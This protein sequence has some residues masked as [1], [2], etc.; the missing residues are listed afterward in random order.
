MTARLDA[1]PNHGQDRSPLPSEM[2]DG[3][4]RHCGSARFGYETTV[5]DGQQFAGAGIQEDDRREVGG[6][7]LC[8]V[9][10]EDRDQFG[11]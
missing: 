5:H 3:N 10:P 6:Q 11:S 2:T 7:V 4:C 8:R 9:V 1:G